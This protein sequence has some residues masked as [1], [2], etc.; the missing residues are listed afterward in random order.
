VFVDTAGLREAHDEIEL[1]GIRRSREA[2]AQAEFIL[3]VL[4]AS[5]PLTAE[6]RRFGEE[7]AG[8]KRIL[9]KNKADLPCRLEL[10]PQTSAVVDVSCLNGQGVEELK[11]AI[12]ALIWSGAIQAEALEVMI[13]SRHQEVLL[14]AREATARG[15]D[16][17]RSGATLELAAAD[18]HIAVNA[19]GEVVGK[20]ATEDLLDLIFSQFCIGK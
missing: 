18:L 6:D 8:K 10:I 12:K 1:E 4:D 5:E 7:F 16:A 13:N 3:H 20:T 9:V 2:L 19:V 14:R 11:D 15:R 17:L